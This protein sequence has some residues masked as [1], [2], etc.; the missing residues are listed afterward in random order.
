MTNTRNTTKKY[1]EPYTRK[2]L[3]RHGD[4]KKVATVTGVSYGNIQQQL[5]GYRKIHPVVKAHFDK[6]ANEN[7]A[8]ID[9]MIK[10]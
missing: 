6:I 2:D 1:G 10:K 8:L 5:A 7:Q 9:S 3:L 4:I